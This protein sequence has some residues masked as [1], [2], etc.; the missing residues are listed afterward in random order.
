M[1]KHSQALKQIQDVIRKELDAA[2][3]NELNSY[4]DNLSESAVFYPP[5]SVGKKDK[6]LKQ[7]LGDF[8]ADFRVGWLN[9]DHLEISIISNLA[10]HIYSYKWKITPNSGGNPSVF[11]GTGMRILRRMSTANGRLN[12]N[13]GIHR[14]MSIS[15]LTKREPHGRFRLGGGSELLLELINS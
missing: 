2:A 7:F 14:Q 15:I 6:D 5:N 10:Y 4:L 3:N 9:F 13:F 1:T 12:V 8:L 11:T